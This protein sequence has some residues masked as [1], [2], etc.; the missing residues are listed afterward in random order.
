MPSKPGGVKYHMH[1][2][3]HAQCV[4][5]PRFLNAFVQGSLDFLLNCGGVPDQLHVQEAIDALLNRGSDG[6]GLP[7]VGLPGVGLPGAG[8]PGSSGDVF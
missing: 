4:S 1:K 2:F 6:V 8:L 7:G 5:D 3:V